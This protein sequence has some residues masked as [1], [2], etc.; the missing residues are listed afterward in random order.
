MKPTAEMLALRDP[1]R[2]ALIGALPGS[3]FGG[4][5]DFGVDFGVDFGDD[6]IGDDFGDDMGVDFG[7]AATLAPKITK[8]A[9]IA[10]W[11][12][13]HIKKNK[14]ARR[15]MLLEPNHGSEIKVER[16]SFAINQTLTLGTAVAL[17]MTGSPDTN[18]RPQRVMMNAPS[19]GFCTISEIKVANVSVTV[20]GT[21]DAFEFGPLAVDA[22]LDM[23]T[24]TPSNKATV[25]GN[26]TGFL[27]TGFVL[28]AS[29]TFVA[30]FKGP[31]S[32][33]A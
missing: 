19:M 16:Y 9:A 24:L 3:D 28:A 10:A 20:G 27:P 13:H 22:T 18:I 17:S 15:A 21:A 29:Y 1:A 7:A 23:P 5:S 33:V 11:K 31:A 14:T 12:Q 6:D 8:S 2:A 32:I 30:S 25:L 4:E 26:Y